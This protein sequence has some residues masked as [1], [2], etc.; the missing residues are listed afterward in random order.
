MA[1]ASTKRAASKTTKARK[2]RTG[3]AGK[4]TGG[5]GAVRRIDI[6]PLM[7]GQIRLQLIGDRPLLVNNKLNVADDVAAQYSGAGKAA[8]IKKDPLSIEEQYRRAFYVLPSSKYQAPDKRAK[9]GIVAS[10]TKKCV[11]AAIRTTGITDNTTI[12]LISNSFW[13]LADEAGLCKITFDKLEMDTR[14]VNIGSGQKTVP[15]MRYRPMF[16]G[17]KCTVSVTYNPKVLGPEQI[18]NLFMHAGQYIGWGE[19]RAQKKQGECGGFV[20]KAVE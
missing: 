1:K 19:L 20:I 12:G 14:P 18:I 4:D 16:H 3:A 13:V 9:Y 6:P 11:C 7:Q 15:Q 5:N 2:T 8:R 17:W 10:G